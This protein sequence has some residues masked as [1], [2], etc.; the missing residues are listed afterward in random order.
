MQVISDACTPNDHGG[1]DA[2]GVALY[3]FSTNGNACGPCAAALAAVQGADAT[4]YPD[5]AYLALRQRLGAFHGVDAGRIVVAASA[6]EFI[7]RITAAVACR[8]ARAVRLP[9]HSYGDYA[10]AAQA[11]GLR[12]LCPDAAMEAAQLVWCCDPSSPLGQAQPGIGVQ[13]DARAHGATC[14]LDLA[15]EPLRLQGR[16]ALSDAQR[17][18]AWQLWTPNK[19]LGLTG[20][21]AAY[22][23]VPNDPGGAAVQQQLECMAPSWPLGAHGVALLDVWCT[24]EV[25]R[26]L[27]QSRG[28]LRLWKAAQRAL[29]RDTLGWACL[30]SDANFFCAKP[31]FPHGTTMQQMLAELRARGIKLRDCASFGLP[32]HV[33][34]SVQ[35]PAAQDALR[36]AWQQL[37]KVSR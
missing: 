3:D 36:N 2:Q 31:V 26:W 14:V 32:G 1:P 27:A 6:S 16:L 5:P 34:V 10:K 18:G 21:R 9:V 11:W 33:R 20:V 37:I 12:T 25:Q 13:L 8:D 17:D 35:P 7:F 23:I 28:T 19:S 4:R 15:Y 24:N 29:L 30:A 22:A